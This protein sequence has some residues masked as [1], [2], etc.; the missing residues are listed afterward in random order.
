VSAAL[1][2]AIQTDTRLTLQAL[3]GQL[4]S[5]SNPVVLMTMLRQ[6]GTRGTAVWSQRMACAAALVNAFV[7]NPRVVVL[8][9]VLQSLRQGGSAFDRI[10]A[11]EAKRCK[12]GEGEKEA[13]LSNLS[14]L[15][16]VVLPNVFSEI[17]AW[18]AD[19]Q[20]NAVFILCAALHLINAEMVVPALW[21]GM[22]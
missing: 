14:M 7:S 2:L 16:G 11:V 6:V 3:A 10:L 13:M 12:L 22:S 18:T 9:P 15:S 19:T 5:L 21:P 17:Y 4:V 1:L 20:P 8:A